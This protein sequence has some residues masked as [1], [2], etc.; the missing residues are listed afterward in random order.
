MYV[1]RENGDIVIPHDT[2]MKRLRIRAA[3]A[4]MTAIDERNYIERD[5]T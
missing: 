1:K 2:S 3:I 4:G 5:I